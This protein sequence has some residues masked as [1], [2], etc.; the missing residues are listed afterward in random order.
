MSD[1]ISLTE[2]T[3]R[4]VQL[5]AADQA[6]FLTD[7]RGRI[8][9]TPTITPGTVVLNPQQYVGVA[10]MPS[11]VTLDLLPKV[12]LY[13]VM[14]MI[15]EVERLEG[16]RFE[17]LD[18]DVPIRTF[19]DILE[20]IARSFVEQV[21]HLIDRGLYRTYI[22]QEDNLTAIRGRID[23]R[24]DLNRNVILRHRTY[25][26][27]TEY[28]WDIPENQVIRQVVHTLARWG[29]STR[30]TDRLI[31]LDRQ[32]ED[33]SRTH[34]RAS[35]ISRFHYSRQSDHY[36]PIH[37][38]CRLFLDGFSLSEGVGTSGFNGFLMDM[39]KLFESF[40][41]IRLDAAIQRV[42]TQMQLSRQR[43]FPLFHDRS[44]TINP[45][46]V[47]ETR[48]E[49]ALVADTKYKR[50][51]GADGTP[52]DYYQLITY[53]TVLG[54]KHGVIIYPRHESDVD[55]RLVVM[56][57][58]ITIHELSIDLDGSQNEIKKSFDS[59][60]WRLAMLGETYPESAATA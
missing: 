5:A 36:R 2:Y 59:L 60:A 58:D 18:Q 19:D 48:G 41:A 34:M 16:V 45:D 20:P 26:R 54:L 51:S 15:A 39:N 4:E 30:L 21:E 47:L 11:G 22:E 56:G 55:S 53:C 43:S 57:S 31:A 37:R 8:N 28:S 29:F 49:V 33:I 50:R 23:F 38:F 12:D 42:H 7:T 24:E 35:D 9:V 1:R 44:N 46:L 13:N 14:W 6:M 40:V 25:C 32:M 17:R 52:T 3:D 10:R 27:F